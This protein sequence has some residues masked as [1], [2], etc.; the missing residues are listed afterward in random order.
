MMFFPRQGRQDFVLISG[1]TVRERRIAT[2][3]HVKGTCKV[4]F[5]PVPSFER[6]FLVLESYVEVL[7]ENVGYGFAILRDT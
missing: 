5:T 3:W 4:S 6:Y 2:E 1:S 7:H